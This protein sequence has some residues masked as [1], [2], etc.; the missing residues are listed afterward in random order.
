MVTLGVQCVANGARRGTGT[1]GDGGRTNLDYFVARTPESIASEAARIACV[2]CEAVEAPA[3]EIEVVVG[4]GG[5]GV[6][7][8]EAVGHGLES[9]FNRRGT[10]LYSGRVGERV[11]SELVTIY[12]DGNLPEERGSVNVD[13]E[14]TPGQHKVLVENGVLRGYMQD[15]STRA[16]GRRLDRQRTAAVV[17]LLAAAAHVQH[18]HAGRRLDAS[19]RSSPRPSA[20]STRS[21]S[22]AVKSRSARAT[23]SSWSPK[24]I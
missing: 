11:A 23:S 15:R 1:C 24:A 14:G 4:A 22:P 7:L 6:L 10:S 8:H 5:G 20:A 12:D 13:D 16:D 21:R 19:T 3:G 9:D 18:V 17:S 2:N